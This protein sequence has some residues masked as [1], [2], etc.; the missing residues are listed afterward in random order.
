[1]AL[2]VTNAYGRGGDSY[3]CGPGFRWGLAQCPKLNERLALSNDLMMA[4]HELTPSNIIAVLKSLS[5]FVADKDLSSKRLGLY[6]VVL[7]K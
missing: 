5:K 4:D 2:A 3:C 1:M 7:E 6:R